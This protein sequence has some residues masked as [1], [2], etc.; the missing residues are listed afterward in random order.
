MKIRQRRCG[1]PKTAAGRQNHSASYRISARSPRTR[2]SPREVRAGTFSTT[3]CRGPTS[4]MI[5][6]NSDQSPERA[7]SMPAPFPAVLMSWHGNPPQMMSTCSRQF[8]QPLVKEPACAVAASPGPPNKSELTGCG[9][10]TRGHPAFSRTPCT[11]LTSS[12]LR[13][14]GQCLASTFRQYSSC[15]TCH[16]TSCPA[17]SRPSSSPP[18]PENKLPTVTALP[19]SRARTRGRPRGPRR[20]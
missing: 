10:S 15:S 12:Y 7:P 20:T 3:T 2:S 13:A 9:S 17:R 5:L 8:G 11:S 18:I 4:R 16:T 6:A 19:V 1:A 14:S